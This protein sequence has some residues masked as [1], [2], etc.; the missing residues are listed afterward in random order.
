MYCKRSFKT[1]K[2]GESPLALTIL[3]LV[4]DE[5]YIIAAF[6]STYLTNHLLDFFYDFRISK[7][8]NVT[9]VSIV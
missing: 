1:K 3:Q 6:T 7:S 9:D 5:Y 2:N 4:V 8:H